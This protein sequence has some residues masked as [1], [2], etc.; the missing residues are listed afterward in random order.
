ML[1]N[2]GPARLAM[3]AATAAVLIGFFVFLGIKVTQPKMVLLYGNLDLQESAEIVTRLEAQ[4]IPYQIGSNG[5]QI[6]VPEDRMLRVRMQ[7]AEAGLP[8]GGS[9]GYEIFDKTNAL[10]ATN[11]MQ[12]INHLRALEGELARTIRAIDQVQSARVHLVLPKREVFSRD[13]R[14][15]SASIIIKT[16]GGRLDQPQVRAI[17]NLVASAVPDLKPSRISVVD[18]RG[19]LLAGTQE[20]PDPAT[21]AATRMEEMRRQAE[22]RLRK[23]IE[24][25]LERS[26]GIGNVRAEVAVD[27][28]FDRVTT[29]QELFD[30]DQQVVRST[31]TITEENQSQE[32]QQNVTV[33][34]NLPEAQNQGGAQATSRANRTEELVNYEIS[35]TVRTQV[36]E[37]GVM[38]RISAAVLVNHIVLVDGQGK[39][40]YQPRSPEELQQLT[41]LVRNAIGYNPERGDN[42]EVVSMRFAEPG[43]IPEEVD[44]NSLPIFMGLTKADL[45]RIGEI[46]GYVLL[47]LLAMLLV[48]RPMIR[49][50]LEASHEGEEVPPGMLTPAMPSL[51]MVVGGAPVAELPAA[52]DAGMAPPTPGIESMIDIARIEGQVKASSLKK[53]GEIVDKHPEEAVSIIRNWLYQAA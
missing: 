10:S 25:L 16:K 15:P 40:A 1:R 38:R 31:Q 50:I 11:F 51:P 13:Q 36:R 48:V 20:E 8:S 9:M 34:N 18:D 4:R 26:V 14:E 35:K 29:N 49:R 52:P 39:R 19:N 24:A 5:T 3:L 33:A 28:D 45:F 41:A 22:E 17:Q 23:N 46:A 7:L 27:M 32:G 21:A 2:I 12:N 53:I 37:A 43:D 42:V 30:P 44:P 6:L 47:G